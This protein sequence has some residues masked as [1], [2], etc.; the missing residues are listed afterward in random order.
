VQGKHVFL[1]GKVIPG[2]GS[3]T[4][5]TGDL[6][7]FCKGGFD[8]FGDQGDRKDMI[9][10]CCDTSQENNVYHWTFC[11]DS[12][13]AT[14]A[15]MPKD[16]C[17]AALSEL[18]SGGSYFRPS[19]CYQAE[20]GSDCLV[21]PEEGSDSSLRF[22][23]VIPSPSPP[24]APP[25]PPPSPQ[26]PTGEL[27]TTVADLRFALE[28]ARERSSEGEGTTLYLGRG[29][30]DL[31]GD[32][33]IVYG[34]KNITIVSGEGARLEPVP[35]HAWPGR[36]ALLSAA[37]VAGLLARTRPRLPHAPLPSRDSQMSRRS[38]TARAS[39]ASSRCTRRL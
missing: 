1:E 2:W 23:T 15:T 19:N 12:D 27:I 37:P 9:K 4:C 35:P 28:A 17:H 20:S 32:P 3:R 7:Y 18:R 6:D 25:P 14:I 38:S 34:H 10:H 21:W 24:P 13:P 16:N 29:T 22:S 30:Y 31:G 39:L 26:R 36:R 5:A 11:W 33:L 8:S